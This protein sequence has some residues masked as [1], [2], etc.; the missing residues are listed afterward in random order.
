MVIQEPE[1]ILASLEVVS[2][3]YLLQQA[4][5]MRRAGH[6]NVISYSRKV[7]IPLTQLCRDVAANAPSP[8]RRAKS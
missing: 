7:F 4:T 6:G 8:K 3:S 2:Q 1:R 5:A